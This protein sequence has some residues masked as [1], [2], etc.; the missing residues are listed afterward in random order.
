ML[1]AGCWMGRCQ[2]LR[3]WIGVG[4]LDV[5]FADLNLTADS[6]EHLQTPKPDRRQPHHVVAYSRLEPLDPWFRDACAILDGRV[7]EE[8]ALILPRGRWERIWEVFHVC[9]CLGMDIFCWQMEIVQGDI[10]G[11]R[12]GRSVVQVVWPFI[13]DSIS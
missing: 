10:T 12:K 1:D 8:S 13:F 6:A 4:C 11:S 2:Q 7:R 3:I 9:V 5:V